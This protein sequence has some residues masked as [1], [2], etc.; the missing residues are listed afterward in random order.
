[1]HS[2]VNPKSRKKLF[3]IDFGSGLPEFLYGTSILW[4]VKSSDRTNID[5]FA[6]SS[7]RPEWGAQIND[8]ECRSLICEER[9]NDNFRFPQRNYEVQKVTPGLFATLAACRTLQITPMA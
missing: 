1:V 5:D 9:G 2:F 3:P 8:V 6:K 4:S 7:M